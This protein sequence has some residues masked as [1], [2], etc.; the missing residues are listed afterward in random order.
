MGTYEFKKAINLYILWI[1]TVKLYVNNYTGFGIV[2]D[3]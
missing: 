3:K 2:R 1:K